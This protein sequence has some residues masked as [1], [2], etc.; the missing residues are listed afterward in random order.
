M[1]EVRWEMCGRG[2]KVKSEKIERKIEAV[3]MCIAILFGDVAVTAI[4][5]L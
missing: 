4:L 2:R 1:G 3:G 5:L